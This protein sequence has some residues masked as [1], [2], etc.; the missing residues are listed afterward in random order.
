MANTIQHKRSSVVGKVPTSA[1]LAVGEIAINFADKLIY[2]KNTDGNVIVIAYGTLERFTGNIV[3]SQNVT[4]T[5]GNSTHRFSNLFLSGSTIDLGGASIKYEGGF[6]KVLDENGNPAKTLIY[7]ANIV[8]SGNTTSGNVYFTNNRARAALTS[9]NTISYDSTTGNITLSPSG[10]TAASY[11][12]ASLIP[13]LTVDQFGRVT[14]VSNVSVAGV[15]NF[16]ASGNAFT[17]QTSAGTSF[18]ANIQPNSV[19]LGTDTTGDYVSNLTAG[20][21]VV[22]SNLGGEGIN[23]TI[24]IGQNVA[25]TADVTFS[26]VTV[27]GN[28]IASNISGSQTNTTIIAGSYAFSFDNAGNL[29]AP[30]AINTGT[31]NARSWNNLYTNNV[32]EGTNLYFTNA[33]SYANTLT[34]IKTGNGIVYNSTTGNIT[35]NPT[36]VT[37]STYGGSSNVSVITVDQFGRITSAANAAV[38]GVS[39]FSSAG[40]AFTITTSSGSTFIA[41]IQPNSVRLGTDTTGDYVANLV[42]GTGVTISNFSGEGITPTISIGQNVDT[43]ADVTFANITITGNLSVLGNAVQFNANTLVIDD[44]LIQVGA[45]NNLSDSV[46][47]GFFGHYKSGTPSIERHAGLFRDASDGN[48]KLFANLDPTPDVVVDTS[49]V[50]F[51]FA[52]LIVNYLTGNVLGTVNTLSNFSTSNLS[53]GTNLYYT[54]AR[55]YSNVAPLLTTANVSEVTN[56][57]FTNARVYEA[58][59]DNLALKA[60]VTDLTTSNV[61][62]GINL[63]FTNAKARAAISAFDSTI[64]YDTANGTIRANTAALGA[65]VLSVNGKTGTVVLTT[66]DISEDPANLYYTNARVYAAV[67]GNLA[68]KANVVDLTT[69]NVS[70]GA[71]LYFTN[72]RVY[73]NIAPLLTTANVLEVTNLYFTNARSY[74]NTLIALRSGNGINYNNVTGNITLTATGVTVATYGGSANIPVVTIDTFGRISSASNVAVA[75]VSSFTSSGNS[76][77]IS[78]GAGTSFTANIQPDSIRLGT[79]TTGPYV[80]NLVAGTGVTLTGLGNEGTTPTIAIGQS[81]ATTSDVVFANITATGNV[82]VL[83]NVNV[84]NL[85]GNFT[86]TTITAGSYVFTFDNAGNVTIPTAVNAN[87]INATFWNNLY[88]NNVVE[89]VNLYFTNA[90]S[91]SNTLVALRSGNGISYN[92]VTGNITLTATGV[93]SSTYGGTSQIP[94]F[95]VDSFGRLTNASNV[96][97]AGVNAFTSSGNSFT[98]STAAGTSFTANLQPDSV[99]LGTDTTG[100]YVANLLFGNGIIISN[101]TGEGAT[102]NINLTTTGVTAATYGSNENIPIITVDTYGRITSA[103]NVSVSGSSRGDFV[104]PNSTLSAFPG[105]SGNIDYGSSETHVQAI[106]SDSFGVFTTGDI[107]SLMDPNYSVISVDLGAL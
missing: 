67:T 107:F 27:T 16:T 52:N 21:G 72:A 35:L 79:D 48:F 31:I 86:N 104:Y 39:S 65:N 73:S 55:V 29:T 98:I 66:V 94:V 14:G 47:L 26:N 53:E 11:G 101:L 12:N 62:E 37:A 63:Y 24:A 103:A 93:T 92:N 22:L 99:R 85:I 18:T 83:G 5:L 42:A 61:A 68:L 4:Y 30:T 17:I 75:G 84:G 25:T 45:N 8:E 33:R 58:V 81:V 78:T 76:F 10:V 3:P 34:A 15:N 69:S 46:D 44:P 7:T 96:A 43:H 1:N 89:S 95:T 41:N 71:N 19:R 82:T 13:S 38:A 77:T 23:P 97:V 56:L 28:V 100:E 20:T 87:T 59:T 50:S 88:T 32:I 91:Y 40:N 102:P 70:E 90:R 74:A 60:N 105:S 49:N 2:T 57:Y 80:A 9:G 36:G 64:V 51:N 106:T 54:N 6:F